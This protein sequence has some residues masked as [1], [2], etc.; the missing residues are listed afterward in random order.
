MRVF[1]TGVIPGLGVEKGAGRGTYF[2]KVG[3]LSPLLHATFQC[4]NMSR[5]QSRL[6][7]T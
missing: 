6:G 7:A 3:C 2:I 4:F 1:D 5:K